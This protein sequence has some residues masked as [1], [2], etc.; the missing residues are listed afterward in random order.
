MNN[1]IEQGVEIQRCAIPA[2][3][4]SELSTVVA[5][6]QQH[7]KTTSIRHAD[8]KIPAIRSFANSLLITELAGQHIAGTPQLVRA[9][10]FDK[11]PEEN[12]RVGA[13]L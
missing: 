13:T 12:W 2:N 10:V 1:T 9:I 7:N 5:K 11:T 4:I 8:L 6:Y 3:I